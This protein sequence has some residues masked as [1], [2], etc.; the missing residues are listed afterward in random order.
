VIAFG[1][2]M[3]GMFV[4]DEIIKGAMSLNLPGRDQARQTATAFLNRWP[5]A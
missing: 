4:E 2:G 1:Q 3:S 5:A